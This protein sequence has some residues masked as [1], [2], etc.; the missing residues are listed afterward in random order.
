MITIVPPTNTFQYLK[1]SARLVDAVDIANIVLDDPRFVDWS[2]SASEGSHHYGRGGLMQHTL[3]VMMLMVR[4]YELYDSKNLRLNKKF[5]LPHCFMMLVKCGTT[6][7][8]RTEWLRGSPLH[9]RE[10]F[11]ISLVL[12]SSGAGQWTSFQDTEI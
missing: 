5:T 9:T 10:S 1:S 6:N 2:G 8:K 11:I 12:L 7:H 3:E 4:A